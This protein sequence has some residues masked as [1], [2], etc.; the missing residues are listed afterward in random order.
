MVLLLSALRMITCTAFSGPMSFGKMVAPPQPGTSP[1][2]HSGSAV[3]AVLASVRYLQWSATSSPPPSAKPL[4]NANVGFLPSFNRRKTSWPSF[5]IANAC[6][7]SVKKARPDRSAPAAKIKGLP[8]IAMATDSD[9]SA[10]S[11]AAFRVRSDCGP[12][13]LG[14]V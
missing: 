13:V 8:V 11:I 12:K 3:K 9:F 1:R 7:L 14:R 4:I 10:V 5:P 6:D 2:K